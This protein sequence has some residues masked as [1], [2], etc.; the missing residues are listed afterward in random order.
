MFVRA[1]L[2]LAV[3]AVL[4]PHEP[5][6]RISASAVP[7]SCRIRTA[8]YRACRALG[9]SESDCQAA[10]DP[11]T[12]DLQSLVFDK[13]RA[14]KADLEAN[15]GPG[16]LSLVFTLKG[17]SSCMPRPKMSVSSMGCSTAA[18]L[19]G[20]ALYWFDLGPVLHRCGRGSP[21]RLRLMC[22]QHVV[23][24]VPDEFVLFQPT[25]FFLVVRSCAAGSALSVAQ[26]V[27]T[28]LLKLFFGT[29]AAEKIASLSAWRRRRRSD[30]ARAPTQQRIRHPSSPRT[31]APSADVDPVARLTTVGHAGRDGPRLGF[32]PVYDLRRGTASTFLCT[33]MDGAPAGQLDGID[34]RDR[35]SLDEAMLERCLHLTR[36][37][38]ARAPDSG[39][40][41]ARRLRNAGVVARSPPLSIGTAQF[42]CR[43]QSVSWSSR[44]RMSRPGRRPPVSPRS[45]PRC[46]AMRG[47]FSSS[48]PMPMRG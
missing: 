27:N 1:T 12:G 26:T 23:R 15:R 21:A 7:A 18:A 41:S 25:G 36:E 10:A 6:S 4:L 46:A 19:M 9:G 40:G 39:C 42:R 24:L 30:V 16:G 14:V 2:A 17:T 20:K 13:L 34:P 3:I 32:L 11:Q 8:S 48:S 44:S 22:E 33:P 28:A 38:A 37:I 5:T 29:D 47:E 43:R 35:L 45:L 31:P